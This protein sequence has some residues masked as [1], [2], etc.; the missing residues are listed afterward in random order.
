MKLRT[1]FGAQ[2]GLGAM[3]LLAGC[4]QGKLREAEQ[5]AAAAEARV[6]EMNTI[7]AAKDT[8]M[9]EL[10]QTTSFI[11]QINDELAKVKPAKG[12]KTVT[13]NERVMPAAEYRANVM[14]RIQSLIKRLDD[15]EARLQ[16]SQTRLSQLGARDEA[17]DSMVVQYRAL[18]DEQREQ[19]V[20]LT[21]QVDTLQADRTRLVFE[22]AALDTAVTQL[23]TETNTVY[24]TVGTK[25]ELLQRGVVTE[26]GGARVLGIF[27][28]AGKTLVPARNI[29]NTEFTQAD[30]RT[31]VDIVFPKANRP[32]SIVSPHSTSHIQPAPDKDGKIL[33]GSF[34]IQDPAV[35]WAQSKYLIVVER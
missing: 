31:L 8:L 12:Q 11:T 15:A 21:A 26:V 3:L 2:I 35:F 14:T 19:I 1:T 16:S 13:Y 9:T 23:T 4:N 22:K 5:R 29:P 24:F 33:G 28:K 7:T 6:T 17:L 30:K 20:L 25:E 27:G 32:Y 18:M 34:Q 10:M